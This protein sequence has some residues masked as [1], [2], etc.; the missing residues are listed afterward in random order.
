VRVVFISLLIC[1]SYGCADLL[2][3]EGSAPAT[4]KTRAQGYGRSLG[5]LP[6]QD[7]QSLEGSFRGAP[8]W[9]SNNP[10]DVEGYGLLSS[11]RVTEPQPRPRALT[12]G[13]P[14]PELQWA[15]AGVKV[16][17]LQGCTVGSFKR[18]NVYLAH[19]L[20]S[21]HLSGGRRLSVV[22]EADDDLSLSYQ[23]ALGTTT[24]SDIRGFKTTRA[25]WLGAQV[26][27]DALNRSSALRARGAQIEGEVSL[28]GGAR[29]ILKTIEVE[30][31]VEGGL[32]LT[33][34]GGCFALH[35]IAHDRPLD[36]LDPLPGFARG[37]VKWPGWYQGQGFGRASGL[38]E[39]SEWLGEASATLEPEVGAFG[40]R[41]FD[42]AHSP[43]ALGRHADSAEVLFGGYGVVYEARLQLS[44][45]SDVCVSAQLG[46]TSYANLTLKAGE[47]PLGA[48]R[49]P[50]V[51]DLAKSDP[52]ARPSMLWNGPI[53]LSQQLRSGALVDQRHSVILTPTIAQDEWTS[54]INVPKGIH[55]PLLRWDLSPGEERLASLLIPV[56]GYIVAP[57]ALTVELSA[58]AP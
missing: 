19:I 23:G 28:E 41:L 3:P 29:F 30:S 47:A 33:S 55:K 57:A 45:P 21:R 6:Y 22:V 10:E 43:V 7:L 27:Q 39:G 16:S 50:S 8:L 1:V 13:A 49:T 2:E 44:N 38:Y 31:L 58:C 12:E 46:F 4:E 34:E 24:W 26:A 14:S 35:V 48:L 20:S 53:V 36:P 25:E 56:P 51:A 52:S 37:D 11:T 40:W 5:E 42:E 9:V 15:E 54:P 18:L 32:S 17:E